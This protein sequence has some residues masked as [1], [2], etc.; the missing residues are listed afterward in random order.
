MC[1]LLL[2]YILV[3]II[4]NYQTGLLLVNRSIKRSPI[5]RQ[6]GFF[7][8]DIDQL[9][10]VINIQWDRNDIVSVEVAVQNPCRNSITIQTN[11]KIK[12]GGTVTNHGWISCGALEKESLLKSR[13][14]CEFLGHSWGKGNSPNQTVWPCSFCQ[15]I[16]LSWQRYAVGR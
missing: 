3:L 13:R 6:A 1:R 7:M 9:N 8:L 2:A 10:R 12:E 5:F 11:Q 16:G 15:R 14:S 4:L